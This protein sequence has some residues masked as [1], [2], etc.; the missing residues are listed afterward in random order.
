MKKEDEEEGAEATSPIFCVARNRDRET[1]AQVF[2]IP[3]AS[4]EDGLQ[5]PER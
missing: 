2:C 1:T 3:G 5:A 4:R